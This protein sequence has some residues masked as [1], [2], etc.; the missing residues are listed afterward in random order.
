VLD[1]TQP[2][3]YHEPVIELTN[4]FDFAGNYQ[5]DLRIPNDVEHDVTV[6][7][8][9]SPDSIPTDVFKDAFPVTNIDDEWEFL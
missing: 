9:I 2:V 5:L 7:N 1:Y 6:I 4:Q 3:L 8:S